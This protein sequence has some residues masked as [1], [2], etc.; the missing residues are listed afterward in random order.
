MKLYFH[1]AA[2][3]ELDDAVGYYEE[4][5]AGLGLEFAAEIHATITRILE[6]PG[7]WAPL[8]PSTRRALTNRFP[9]SLVYQVHSDT[10]RIIAVA[11]FIGVQG[12]G[13]IGRNRHS[14]KSTSSASRSPLADPLPGLG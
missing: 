4:R 7:A 1:P 11:I 3:A 12:T 8:S 2:E 14:R 10:L 5:Q 9:Y 6:Y 13:E